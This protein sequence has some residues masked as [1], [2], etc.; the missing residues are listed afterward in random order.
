MLVF[1]VHVNSP[2]PRLPNNY[3]SFALNH[4]L[5][6]TGYE[7]LCVKGEGIGIYNVVFSF[8]CQPNFDGYQPPLFF[9]QP[10]PSVPAP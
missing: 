7:P 6:L 2:P 10:P 5:S 1:A 4:T 3:S 9:A 8:L